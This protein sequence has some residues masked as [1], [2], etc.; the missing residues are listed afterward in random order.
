MPA[1]KYSDTTDAGQAAMPRREIEKHKLYDNIDGTG[2]MLMGSML[3]GFALL[4]CLQNLLPEH[5]IWRTNGFASLLFM[6]GVMALVLGPAYW[7]RSLVKK[8]ITF[9]RTGYV[10]GHSFWRMMLAPKPARTE[11]APGVPTRAGMFC[12]MLGITLIAAIAAASLAGLLAFERKHLGALGNLEILGYAG[13]LCFWLLVYAFWI[14]RMSR[15]QPWKWLFVLL[16]AVGL[17]VVG[18]IHPDDFFEMNRLVT[19]FVGAVWISSG[20]ATLVSYLRHT[21][22]PAAETP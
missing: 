13:Y 9:P 4:G 5:S 20:I 14:W 16:M 7:L 1:I 10:A 15:K 18:I 12:A 21:Q 6:Y 17:L 19:L 22:P 8:H 2:D 3:L 11:T